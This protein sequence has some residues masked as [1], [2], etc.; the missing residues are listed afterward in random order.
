MCTVVMGYCSVSVGPDFTQA[1]NRVFN[2]CSLQR[3][4][5]FW[6]GVGSF[7]CS[8]YY[9]CSSKVI[10]ITKYAI[11]TGNITQVTLLTNVMRY[12]SNEVTVTTVILC[13]IK[14]HG[15]VSCGPRSRRVTPVSILTG[16]KKTQFSHLR[17]SVLP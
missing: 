10:I 7:G 4:M 2:G 9:F 1:C 14:T 13:T 12:Q 15:S 3:K 6:C 5:G 8:N 11:K 16:R 17:S